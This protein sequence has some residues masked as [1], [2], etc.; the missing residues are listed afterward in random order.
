MK[1]VLFLLTMLF[2]VCMAYSQQKIITGKV[3]SKISNDPL[4]GVSVNTKTKTALTD[5][6]GKFSIQASVGETITLSFVGMDPQTL[7]VTN[8]TQN[9]EISMEDALNNLNT[10]VVTGYQTQKKA[11]LTGAVS[12]NR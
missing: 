12:D 3:I 9:L 1:K 5:K 6:D 8:A 11:D 2:I 7:K 10:I 4:V